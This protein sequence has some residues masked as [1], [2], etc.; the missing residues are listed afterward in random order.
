FFI[1]L[2]SSLSLV[3]NL[4]KISFYLTII[5]IL[6][7]AVFNV[8]DEFKNGIARAAGALGVPIAVAAIF[9]SQIISE[10]SFSFKNILYILFI[11][12]I[13]SSGDSLLKI[14]FYKGVFDYENSSDNKNK[15]KGLQ[16]N[17]ALAVLLEKTALFLDWLRIPSAMVISVTFYM[18]KL[19]SLENALYIFAIALL[20]LEPGL[21]RKV[22]SIVNIRLGAQILQLGG[23]L[24]DAKS[25]SDIASCNQMLFTGSVLFEQKVNLTNWKSFT[26]VKTD[27]V[28]AALQAV[29]RRIDNRYSRAIIDFLKD[30]N[31]P[32][33]DGAEFDFIKGTGVIAQTPHGRILCGNRNLMLD[34]AI[35]TASYE[36]TVNDDELK[37]GRIFFVALDDEI[38]ACFTLFDEPLKDVR[39]MMGLLVKNGIEPVFF[40]SLEYEAAKGMGKKL[41]IENVISTCND[42]TLQDVLSNLSNSG[43]RTILAGEGPCF[44]SAF[45]DA[46]ATIMTGKRTEK[47]VL[48]GIDARGVNLF[49]IVEIVKKI[50]RTGFKIKLNLLIVLLFIFVGL[51]LATGWYTIFMS[52]IITSMSVMISIF[53]SLNISV[54]SPPWII[55]FS[56][57][58]KSYRF[59]G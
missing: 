10:S 52:L 54:K 8:F 23:R 50:K 30:K 37:G 59:R 38:V 1:I 32:L 5:P 26:E 45:I 58:I 11:V 7:F 19:C 34:N 47:T 46:D 48:S 24:R 28:F 20:V 27:H 56:E 53:C 41:G 40:T 13:Y 9:I 15:G 42:Q 25:A 22:T 17:S 21:L 4:H 16:N 49:S 33:M 6:T 14:I 51:T 29:Q 35:S 39:K 43:N 3:T 18:F 2:L 57:R 36:H 44:E 31:V 12:F 55:L